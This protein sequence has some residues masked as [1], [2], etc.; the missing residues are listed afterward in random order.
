MS[1]TLRDPNA[2]LLK[3]HTHHPEINSNCCTRFQKSPLHIAIE[4]TQ[5]TSEI[6]KS[7]RNCEM[8]KS[9]L[10]SYNH[11]WI[12]MKSSPKTLNS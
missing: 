6:M 9:P 3:S 2:T 1:L 5:I 11:T 12:M 8:T 4:I 7:L 10:K